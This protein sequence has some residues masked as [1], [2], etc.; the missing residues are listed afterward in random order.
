MRVAGKGVADQHGVGPVGGKCSPGL[1]GQCDFPQGPAALQ[2]K[3]VG[4]FQ[5]VELAVADGIAGPPC[6]GYR[7]VG[8]I[9]PGMGSRDGSLSWLRGRTIRGAAL[10]ASRHGPPFACLGE[11]HRWHSGK[12]RTLGCLRLGQRPHPPPKRASTLGVPPRLLDSPPQHA[13]PGGEPLLMYPTRVA[14]RRSKAQPFTAGGLKL[15]RPPDP[16]CRG[17]RGDRRWR[18][19]P[20]WARPARAGAGGA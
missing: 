9:A 7:Q 15:A 18:T 6:A 3:V 12:A 14:G 1:V 2:L 5:G 19:S 4:A 10:V 17:R 11:G 13:V 16:T 20:Q 8:A